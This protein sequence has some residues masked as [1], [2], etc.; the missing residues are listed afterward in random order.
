MNTR[1]KIRNKALEMFNERGIEYVG[2]REIAAGLN[3]RVGNLTYYFPTK[4]DLVSELALELSKANAA[5]FAAAFE[6]TPAGFLQLLRTVYTNH[7]RFRCLVISVVHLMSQNTVLAANY[8]KNRSLRSTG[9]E[10]RLKQ[11]AE[12]G[13]LKFPDSDALNTLIDTISLISRFWVSDAA[14][15]QP[16]MA[17]AQQLEH[18]LSIVAGL[19]KSF[20]TA[21]GARA[22]E[23]S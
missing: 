21:K 12:D 19:L 8:R 9:I 13:Y 18:Y 20:A 7:I 15:I 17:H 4:D 23:N 16:S 22:L 6:P 1:E 2:L 3:I 10:R 11:L 5:A 14:V